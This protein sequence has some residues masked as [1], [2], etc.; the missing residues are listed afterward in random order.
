MDNRRVLLYHKQATSARTL[1]LDHA[2]GSV[3]APGP[4]PALSS[5]AEED[6]ERGLSGLL[7][8]P[9]ALLKELSGELGLAMGLLEIDAEF[10]VLVDTPPGPVAVYL[11]HFTTMDPPR[12]LMGEK[13]ASFLPLTALRGRHP[14]EMEL[15]RRAYASILGG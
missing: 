7:P 13:G 12:A 15:L 10:R 14:A 4:L 8:H 1:F 2:H 3:L 9:A 6:D 5:V 11:A